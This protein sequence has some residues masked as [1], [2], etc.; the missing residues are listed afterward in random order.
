MLKSPKEFRQEIQQAVFPEEVKKEKQ[1]ERKRER[2]R[3]RSKKNIY[4]VST[5][6]WNK[7]K[8][9]DKQKYKTALRNAKKS[10]KPLA[11]YL[12]DI[13]SSENAQIGFFPSDEESEILRQFVL[14]RRQKQEEY[15]KDENNFERILLKVLQHVL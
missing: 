11:R 13:A 6:K 3:Q 4:E 7:T 15:T 12:K 14:K 2:E 10:Q 1:K 5:V 9:D 8:V